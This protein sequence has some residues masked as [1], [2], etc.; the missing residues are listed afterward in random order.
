MG[1]QSTNSKWMRL[2]DSILVSSPDMMDKSCV[3][4]ASTAFEFLNAS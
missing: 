1:K 2:T 4:R 3:V